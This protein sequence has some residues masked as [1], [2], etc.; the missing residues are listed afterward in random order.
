MTTPPD[1]PPDSSLDQRV[2]SLENGHA[3]ILGK[4][5]QLLGSQA[6]A[7]PAS[8]ERPEIGITQE[9][10]DGLAAINGKLDQ[11]PAAPAAADLAE[12][13]PKPPARRI[14]RALWGSDE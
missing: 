4:L 10:R 13:P 8:P 2:A 5:D 6:P 7:A 11:R 3:T 1:P 9:I 14:T 12:Q